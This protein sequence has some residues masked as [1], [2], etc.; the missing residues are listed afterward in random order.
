[1]SKDEK[2]KALAALVKKRRDTK[3]INEYKGCKNISYASPKFDND[4]YGYKYCATPTTKGACNV[5]SRVMFVLNDYISIEGVDKINN[6]GK[7]NN[8]V[9]LGYK[10]WGGTA[11][12]NT[13]LNKNI[14]GNHLNLRR[15]DVFITNIF[16]FIKPGGMEDIIPP[17]ALIKGLEFFEE[18]MNIVQPRVIFILGGTSKRVFCD[19]FYNNDLYNITN[20]NISGCSI[21]NK[22]LSCNVFFM[23]HPRVYDQNDWDKLLD[24]NKIIMSII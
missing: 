22:S 2:L 6:D 23:K 9:E 20:K 1:M 3:M 11:A 13:K 24:L 17:L 5:E 14:I 10:D 21:S 7:M 19:Y 16:S 18:Q 4:K 12:T 15:E 8:L